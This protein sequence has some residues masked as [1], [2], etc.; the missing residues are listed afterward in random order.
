MVKS[1]YTV[2]QDIVLKSKYDTVELSVGASEC[3]LYVLYRA[4]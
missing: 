4:V 2:E 3:L 1:T